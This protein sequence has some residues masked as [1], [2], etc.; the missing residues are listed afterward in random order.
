MS[1]GERFVRCARRVSPLCSWP[2]AR[3][4]GRSRPWLTVVLGLVVI[5]YALLFSARKE[6]VLFNAYFVI[7]AN[8]FGEVWIIQERAL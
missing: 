7:D 2:S 4:F 1:K 3:W 8:V 6:L 5:G